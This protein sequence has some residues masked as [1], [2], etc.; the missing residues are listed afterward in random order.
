MKQV[1]RTVQQLTAEQRAIAEEF[2]D[3]DISLRE[4]AKKHSKPSSTIVYWVKKLRKEREKGV[5]K[6]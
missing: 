5:D 6:T 2:L 1:G 3:T 4:L